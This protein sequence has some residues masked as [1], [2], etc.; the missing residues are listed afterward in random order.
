MPLL[1][2]GNAESQIRQGV[3]LVLLGQGGSVGLALTEAAMED[4]EEDMT[5]YKVGAPDWKTIPEDFA[6][7]RKTG[8]S[9]NVATYG[10]TAHCA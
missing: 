8:T 3:T 2:N 4:L 1:A 10:G 6:R 5:T 9:T 7:L